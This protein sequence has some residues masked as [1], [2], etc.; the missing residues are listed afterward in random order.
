MRYQL[1]E[2]YPSRHTATSAVTPICAVTPRTLE[3]FRSS[4][5]AQT[6]DPRL[7]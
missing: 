2:S 6:R 5:A 1:W 4:W 3:V 7:R